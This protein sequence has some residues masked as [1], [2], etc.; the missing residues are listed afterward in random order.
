MQGEYEKGKE[1]DDGQANEEEVGQ[2][3]GII[4]A[5]KTVEE[6]RVERVNDEQEGR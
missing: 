3:R 2:Q 4:R 1:E 6:R 5:A